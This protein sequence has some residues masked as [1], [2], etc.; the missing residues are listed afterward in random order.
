MKCDHV[1]DQ[2]PCP[3]VLCCVL[4]PA[5]FVF[6]VISHDRA[7]MENCCTQ[8]LELDHAGFTAMHPFGGAGSYDAFKQ[9][10]C[11]L[12]TC[13][14]LATS[15]TTV[16]LMYIYYPAVLLYQ[17]SCSSS[18]VPVLPSTAITVPSTFLGSH[19]GRAGGGPAHQRVASNTRVTNSV[20]SIRP[21]LHHGTVAVSTPSPV[22]C[23]CCHVLCCVL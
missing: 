10:S 2:E 23:V 3:A 18:A 21:Y 17:Y 22:C 12:T 4:L 11:A 7:F 6:S 8:L 15:C 16:L 14:P 13:M 1:A 20:V 5:S 19:V 9:V